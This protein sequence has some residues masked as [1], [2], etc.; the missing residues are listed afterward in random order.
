MSENLLKMLEAIV[1]NSNL[2]QEEKLTLGLRFAALQLDETGAES[3]SMKLGPYKISM[4]IE[5][6]D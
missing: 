4:K 1:N 3:M 5:L 2:D 6:E